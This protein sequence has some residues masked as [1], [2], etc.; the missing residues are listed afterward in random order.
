MFGFEVYLR[1]RYWEV[2]LLRGV[3]ITMMVV[4]NFVT[5]LWLF[6]GYNEHHLSG[7]SSP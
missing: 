1:G 2:D 3:G 4:S 7:A 5:D 6:L